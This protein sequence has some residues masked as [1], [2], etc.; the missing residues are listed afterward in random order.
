M[1]G[2]MYLYMTIQTLFA[3]HALIGTIGRNAC[4]AV[5]A[6]GMEVGNVTLLAQIGLPADQQI[7][8]IGTVRCMA[9]RAVFLHRCVLP[10]E[11]SAFLGM[12]LKAGFVDRV[13]DQVGRTGT[14]VRLM[15]VCAGQQAFVR[16]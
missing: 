3:E 8:V 10:E 7:L 12:A 13:A 1:I 2:A 14:S 11:R 9:I 6:A 5:D 16:Q 4:A 15:A